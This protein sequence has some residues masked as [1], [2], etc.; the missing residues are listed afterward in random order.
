MKSR[1]RGSIEDLGKEGRK[2]KK[3]SSERH[4]S[5]MDSI[6]NRV[7]EE[8][9]VRYKEQATGIW[10]KVEEGNHEKQIATIHPR[11]ISYVPLCHV[12]KC[13]LWK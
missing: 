11:L 1:E 5:I 2:R 6:S 4:G 13:P 8:Y 10:Q 7:N 12:V 3:E 9:K